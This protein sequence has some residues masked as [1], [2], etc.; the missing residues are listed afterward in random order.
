LRAAS[1]DACAI[2]APMVRYVRQRIAPAENASRISFPR[3]AQKSGFGE[4]R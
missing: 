2:H 1:P 4:R 3:F